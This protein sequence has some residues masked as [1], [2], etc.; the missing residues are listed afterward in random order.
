MTFLSGI[1][2]SLAIRA[3][4]ARVGYTAKDH[5]EG[6]RLLHAAAGYDA[7]IPALEAE[8]QV[9]SAI[10]ELAAWDEPHFTSVPGKIGVI[11][12]VCRRGPGF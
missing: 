10:A 5:E 9:T 3:I 2:T 4:L 7:T 6:R 11:D 12:V 8:V 1:G